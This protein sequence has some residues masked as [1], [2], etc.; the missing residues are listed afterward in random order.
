MQAIDLARLL[1]GG[2]VHIQDVPETPEDS[3]LANFFLIKFRTLQ[4]IIPKWEGGVKYLYKVDDGCQN[5]VSEDEEE[6]GTRGLLSPSTSV[7][8]R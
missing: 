7:R 1:S 5:N 8:S 3:H 4:S 6:E 2:K